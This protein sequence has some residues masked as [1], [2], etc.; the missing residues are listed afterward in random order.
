MIIYRFKPG[1]FPEDKARCLAT[2]VGLAV[3]AQFKMHCVGQRPAAGTVADR[4]RIACLMSP[5]EDLESLPGKF[6]H[7]R[8]ER[9][10]F[11][12]P[13]IIE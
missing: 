2:P 4:Y 1:F 5:L 11:E 13:V 12:A 7:L 3:A 6:E 10:L 8:H 9:K